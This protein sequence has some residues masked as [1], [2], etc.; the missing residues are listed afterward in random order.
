MSEINL[1]IVAHLSDRILDEVI[2][3]LSHTHKFLA[4][5]KLSIKR[6]SVNARKVRPQ[7]VVEKFLSLSTSSAKLEHLGKT[8]PKRPKSRAPTRSKVKPLETHEDIH[9]F[10]EGL[11]VF[12]CHH[13]NTMSMPT[14]SPDSDDLRSRTYNN[15]TTTSGNTNV[16][17]SASIGSS[18]YSVMGKMQEKEN[19]KKG[20][21]KCI[22]SLF[23][24]MST[25][26][27]QMHKSKS[28]DMSHKSNV[29]TCITETSSYSSGA[30]GERNFHF[31]KREKKENEEIIVNAQSQQHE[32]GMSC[33][34]A[35]EK[36]W[37]RLP[38]K[39]PGFCILVEMKAHQEKI[40]SVFVKCAMEN[41]TSSEN[42][43]HAV[44]LKST[45][46][47][48]SQ[49]EAFSKD[50]GISPKTGNCNIS[51]GHKHCLPPP[52]TPKPQP[53][54]MLSA[55]EGRFSDATSQIRSMYMGSTGSVDLYSKVP[56]TLTPNLGP[57][58]RSW[59]SST[60]VSETTLTTTERNTLRSGS[61]LMKNKLE[62]EQHPKTSEN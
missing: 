24:W 33:I 26:S 8:R 21:I 50:K 46:L 7:S 10:S 19:E 61:S 40:S 16:S 35:A 57:T 23:S 4:T 5:P 52:I 34:S 18:S 49:T 36:F 6:K 30:E 43:L 28:Y 47:A 9:N 32:E 14:L 59:I 42:L 54:S 48:N 37:V 25:D 17:E 15:S 44:N 31:S 12:F 38:S 1:S 55:F 20:F 56:S 22:S 27:S 29:V 51:P 11:E 45:G 58:K 60:S 53:K 2:E 41:K 13:P 62:I 3:T 39:E